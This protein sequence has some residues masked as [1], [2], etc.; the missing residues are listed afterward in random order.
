MKNHSTLFVVF[1]LACDLASN[2]AAQRISKKDPNA[3]QI[4]DANGNLREYVV[5]PEDYRISDGKR[6]NIVLSTNW[7][8]LSGKSEYAKV[9]STI[10]EGMILQLYHYERIRVS[11][12]NANQRIG[13]YSGGGP[14]MRRI[15]GAP[16]VLDEKCLVKNLPL[17]PIPGK[18][19]PL[20]FRVMRKGYFT[21]DSE[22]LEYF[23]YGLP[24]EPGNLK[25]PAQSE[26]VPENNTRKPIK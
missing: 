26:V 15:P 16:P 9:I 7:V 22:V 24:N 20:N 18:E 10:P 6:Y 11:N 12:L 23:D 8:T 19:Y 3:I 1:L 21:N 5:K 2:A 4:Y 13:G 25:S 14:T 17:A